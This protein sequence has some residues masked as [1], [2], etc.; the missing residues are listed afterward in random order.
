MRLVRSTVLAASLALALG[1]IA[2]AQAAGGGGAGGAGGGAGG[3]T[4]AGRCPP[5]PGG[6]NP[7]VTH[8]GGVEY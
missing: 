4:I 8:Q 3:A 5:L 7:M 2:Q 1:S 6:W